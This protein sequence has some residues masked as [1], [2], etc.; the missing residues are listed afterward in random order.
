MEGNRGT[1]RVSH[2]GKGYTTPSPLVESKNTVGCSNQISKY[3]SNTKKTKG[4]VH[5]YT[6]ISAA[7]L[8]LTEIGNDL[9]RQ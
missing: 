3:L 6:E 7:S 8:Y 5:S 9:T 4:S 1:L 2:S